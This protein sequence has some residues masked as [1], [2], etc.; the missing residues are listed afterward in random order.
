MA[1]N[2]NFDL[3]SWMLTLPVDKSGFTSGVANIVRSISSYSSSYFS[4]IADHLVFTASVS[5]ATT[6]GSNY[7]RSELR[8]LSGSNRAAWNLKQGGT[9]T[10]TLQVNEVPKLADGTAGRVVIGQIHGSSEE[11]VRLYWDKGTIY[12]VNDHAGANNTSQK[13]ALLDANG[14]APNISLNENFSYVISAKDNHL[15]V[16]VYADGMAYTSETV[17]NSIWQSDLFYFKA[18]VYL[19]INEKQG[20]GQGVVSFDALDFSH[21]QGAGF[22]GLVGNAATTLVDVT[23]YT[24]WNTATSAISERNH[25]VGTSGHDQMVGTSDAD[26]LDG[27]AGADTMAGGG[28]DD[29]YYVDNAGDLVSEL[30]NAGT[31]K[32]F[33][34]ISYTLG[35][36]VENLKLVGTDSLSGTGNSLG[37]SMTGNSAANLLSGLS[38]DD[39]LF[40]MGGADTLSG[41]SGKDRLSGGDGNDILTGGSGADKFVFDEALNARSN[42]DT[43]TDFSKSQQDKFYLSNDIFSG[44]GDTGQ[45]ASKYFFVGTSAKTVDQHIIYNPNSG[46]L[47]YD[48]DGSGSGDA[49]LFAQLQKNLALSASDFITF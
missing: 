45:I 30:N 33:S 27:K 48:A 6:T 44:M 21:Q 5:G 23:D 34:S 25:F 46:K 29:F 38:G 12:F 8:E 7:A 1:I 20:T 49:I 16:S 24:G 10:A 31:D 3:N 35:A 40:G 26:R 28:G 37:N 22:N 39:R 41:D 14:N 17:A 11:L 4:Q 42:V 2:Q 36:N 32:V 19:G 43:V 18:G 9:M 15:V 13:F 47:Y